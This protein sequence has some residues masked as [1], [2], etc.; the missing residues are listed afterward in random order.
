M[1]RTYAESCAVLQRDGLLDAGQM[2]PMPDRR[3][4]SDDPEPR[5]VSFFRARVEGDLAEMTLPRTYFGRSQVCDASFCDTD[6]SE[7]TM[8]WCEFIGVDFSD[9][10]LRASDL[11]AS[12]FERVCFDRCDLRDADLRRSTF[13]E[14]RF[15]GC[16][17][18]GARLTHHQRR[19][20]PL[21][22]EQ[23]AEVSWQTE[24]GSEPDGG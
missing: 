13:K 8:C 2:P 16:L 19:D 24:E 4:R 23:D 5:G 17:L 6:L 22:P 21:T 18:G 3:P 15:A 11:R 20:L 14:C 12:T 9:A 10:S 7:S 1:R